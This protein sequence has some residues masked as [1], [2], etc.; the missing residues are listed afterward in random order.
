MPSAGG[1]TQHCASLSHL[2]QQNGQGHSSTSVPKR[3]PPCRAT[4]RPP[5]RGVPW[6]GEAPTPHQGHAAAAGT[7][8]GPG[9][10]SPKPFQ[11]VPSPRH[12]WAPPFCCRSA[13]P[14]PGVH[15]PGRAAPRPAVRGP[16][17]PPGHEAVAQVTSPGWDGDAGTRGGGRSGWQLPLL[18][19][20]LRKIW[21][22]PWAEDTFELS[23]KQEQ[24]QVG[25]SSAGGGSE[26]PAPS[27]FHWVSMGSSVLEHPWAPC[28][29]P[30]PPPQS[31]FLPF[32]SAPPT[33]RGPERPQPRC[34]HGARCWGLAG[35]GVW[36]WW[37]SGQMGTR[38]LGCS[39]A[40]PEG[41]LPG[42][43]SRGCSLGCRGCCP[44][45]GQGLP[46]QP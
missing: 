28:N 17:G 23:R 13:L 34:G 31:L 45:R 46:S 29:L 11:P 1:G 39:P 14:P 21:G 44:S 2:G 5:S 20:R 16:A 25:A 33:L 37:G 41:L 18:L 26:D 30:S 40:P 10:G 8:K 6:G 43:A 24:L 9:G 42:G 32:L 22:L 7:G 12:R 36:L 27:S 19:P 38:G 35:V 4:L 3:S 15:R